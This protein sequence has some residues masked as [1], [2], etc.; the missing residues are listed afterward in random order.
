MLVRGPEG[1]RPLGRPRCEWEDHVGM[2]LRDMVVGGELH[3]SGLGYRLVAPS[4]ECDD[5]SSGFMGGMEFVD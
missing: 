4:C 5:E 3:V 2:G 1:R